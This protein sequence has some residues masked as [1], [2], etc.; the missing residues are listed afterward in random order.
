M[1]GAGRRVLPPRSLSYALPYAIDYRA[2]EGTD[3]AYDHAVLCS[4]PR[5]SSACEKDSRVTRSLVP[6]TRVD[7]QKRSELETRG[8]R[9]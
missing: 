7:R 9:T 6:S 3:A 5:R 1:S 4:H 8:P 2:P